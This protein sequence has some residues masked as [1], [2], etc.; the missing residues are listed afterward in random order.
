MRLSKL[1]PLLGYEKFEI[2][3]EKEFDFLALSSMVLDFD[4]CVFVDDEKV[5]D[6]IAHNVTMILTEN[7]FKEKFEDASYGVCLIEN[8]RVVFF[9][10]HNYLS[11]IEGYKRK[12]DKTSIGKNCKI[13]PLASIAENNVVIGDNVIV[14]EFV[15]IRENTVIREGS[16]VR[17]GAIIGG[18]GFEY[19]RIDDGILSVEH[20]GGVLIGKNVEIQH[21]SCIDRGVYP[22][23]DTII[24]DNSKID[25]LTHIAHGVKI[26][27]N[28]LIAA[29]SLIAG[30][31]VIKKNVW[32]GPGT[33]VSNGLTIGENA[34]VNIGAVVTKNVEDGGSVTGNFAIDHKKFLKNL[35]EI[36]R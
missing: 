11:K 29:H 1:L 25:N 2:I 33:V 36:N 12:A 17:S 22:W 32:I 27:R 7:S 13:S 23:D 15:V 16:I 20:S 18:Q 8:P 26:K 9:E 19:K 34:R 14:E 4:S 5:I 24:E 10:L 21:S 31:V 35:K 30:R 28:V 3:N 6:K